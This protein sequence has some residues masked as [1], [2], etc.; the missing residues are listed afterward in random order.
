MSKVL[1]AVVIPV[2]VLALPSL[3]D[4]HISVFSSAFQSESSRSLGVI[5]PLPL[6]SSLMLD[7]YDI[8]G[9]I[10]QWH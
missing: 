8:E 10:S 5:A 2:P 9:P 1:P 3:C 4:L 7:V 6:G